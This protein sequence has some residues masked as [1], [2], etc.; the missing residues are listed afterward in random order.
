MITIRQKLRPFSLLPATRCLIP[1]TAFVAEVFPALVRIYDLS[2]KAVQEF[3]VAVKG[4]VQNFMVTQDLERGC[5]TVRAGAL[6]YHIL[7][8]LRVVYAKNPSCPTPVQIERLSLG[9]HKKQDWEMIRRR[10]D[11]REIFPLW[12]RLGSLYTPPKQLTSHKGIFSLL[13]ECKRTVAAHKPEKILCAF[14]ELFLAGFGKMLVPRLTDEEHQGILPGAE[15]SAQTS[16]LYLLFEGAQ[17]IRSL[18]VRQKSSEIAIL[19]DLPPE[20][21]SGRMVNLDC[22][23]GRCDVEWTKKTVRRLVFRATS[24]GEIR[25]AFRSWVKKFRVRTSLKDRGW[26]ESNGK[27]LEIKAGSTYLLDRFTK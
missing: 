12:F 10:G 19:P 3:P 25:F 16:P 14:Q 2:G 20:F 24:N 11:F 27:P 26:S 21:A 5:I 23:V 18:F 17:L 15:K 4:P 6:V 7:P 13:Q 8:D 22:D 9:S 1:G